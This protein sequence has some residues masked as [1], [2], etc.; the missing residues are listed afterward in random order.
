MAQ[1]LLE[2]L[3]SPPHPLTVQS[4]GL[5]AAQDDAVHLAMG[6]ASISSSSPSWEVPASRASSRP[7]R[8]RSLSSRRSSGERNQNRRSTPMPS[9]S[10][11]RCQ[12]VLSTTYQP[13]IRSWA[14]TVRIRTVLITAFIK[15][16]GLSPSRRPSS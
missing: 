11:S 2:R 6:G 9:S 1:R 15:V 3:L 13:P 12:P 8:P 4:V 7:S 5:G 16:A 14:G 10:P